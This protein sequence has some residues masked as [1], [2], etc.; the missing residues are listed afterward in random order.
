MRLGKRSKNVLLVEEE[1][2]YRW[3]N[4]ENRRTRK[5]IYVSSLFILAA[6]IFSELI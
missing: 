5:L 2:K 4:S 1:K 3:A 6:L